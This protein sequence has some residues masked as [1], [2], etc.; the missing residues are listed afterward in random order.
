M[1]TKLKKSE[2]T[3]KRII[4]SAQKLFQQK[5]FDATSVREIVEDAG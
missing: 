3:K 5:G 2:A 4:Q 1:Y